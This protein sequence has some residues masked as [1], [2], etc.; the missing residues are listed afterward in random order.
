M[1]SAILA[2]VA[3]AAA[4]LLASGGA[5]APES[6]PSQASAT[7][8]SLVTSTAPAKGAKEE[9]VCRTEHVVG[10]RFPKKTCMTRGEF[11]ERQRIDRAELERAQKGGIKTQ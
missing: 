10:T 6:A 8:V 9:K 5:A 4:A 7:T 2:P 1:I 11:A 3:L